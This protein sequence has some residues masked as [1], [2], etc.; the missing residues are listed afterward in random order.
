L[1]LE[2]E[3]SK[4]STTAL[5]R[6]VIEVFLAKRRRERLR[7]EIRGYA[8]AVAGSAEDLDPALEAAATEHLLNEE[9]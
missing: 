8:E 4:Q 2:A 1:K 7:E 6:R 5:V 9:A 3:A